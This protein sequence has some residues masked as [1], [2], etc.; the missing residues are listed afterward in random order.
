MLIFTN[1]MGCKSF[2]PRTKHDIAQYKR[3][4]ISP[5]SP[6]ALV[7][8]NLCLTERAFLPTTL[9]SRPVP[10]SISSPTF[11]HPQVAS[12]YLSSSES[13]LSSAEARIW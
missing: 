13:T 8:H 7:S 6:Q 1:K 9:T 4:R 10:T 5:R 2:P 3:Y 11:Q 12:V